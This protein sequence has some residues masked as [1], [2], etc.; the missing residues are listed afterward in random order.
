MNPFLH[1]II[2][3]KDTSQ[4]RIL[5]AMIALM[6]CSI[7]MIMASAL[8]LSNL[9]AHWHKSVSHIAT[10]EI[11]K[12]TP[13][14][15]ISELKKLLNNSSLIKDFNLINKDRIKDIIAPWIDQSVLNSEDLPLPT[16][17]TVS[18]NSGSPIERDKLKFSLKALDE[19]IKM[20]THENWLSSAFERA[21]TLKTL[22]WIIGL[23]LTLTLIISLSILTRT[24][25]LLNKEA[26]NLLHISGASDAY[27]VKQFLIYIFGVAFKGILIGCLFA[28][29]LLLTFSSSTTPENSE[30][31]T[32]ATLSSG[33]MSILWTMPFIILVFMLLTTS[34][35]VTNELRKMV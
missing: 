8:F 32:F 23:S 7:L 10:I 20:E 35:T 18:L 21:Q 33:H 15:T 24:R 9:S 34:K 4:D 16:L 6:M 29:L 11:P 1:Q 31:F 30:V 2:P 28:S 12:N 5:M 27:I 13:N 26:I 22:A 25:V 19:N 3:L 14:K 17:L